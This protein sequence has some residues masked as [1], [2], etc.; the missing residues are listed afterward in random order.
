MTAW[1]PSV[2]LATTEN[3]PDDGGAPAKPL[4]PATLD[5]VTVLV[6]NH[7]LVKDQTD[8]S[9]NGTWVATT[10]PGTAMTRR[11]DTFEPESTVRVSEGD[12]NAHTSWTLRAQGAISVGVDPLLFL[13]QDTTRYAFPS[14]AAHKK[15]TAALAATTDSAA[16]A[17]LAG[18]TDPGDQGGGELVFVG[19]PTSAQIDAGTPPSAVV[20]TISAASSSS[21]GV[22]TITTST[23]HGL[24]TGA[25]TNQ[26]SVYIKDVT[27]VPDGPYLV[28]PQSATTFTLDRRFLSAS[29][30]AVPRAHYVAITTVDPHGR[31]AG[32]RLAVSGVV[33]SGGAASVNQAVF[34]GGVI[35]AHT[36]TMPI[37][38]TGGT[39]TP[40]ATAVIGD[41]AILVPATDAAGTTGGLWRR[42]QTEAQVFNVRWFGAV[43]DADSLGGGNDD[44]AAIRATIVAAKKFAAG[45]SSRGSNIAAA[46]VLFPHG[47]YRVAAASCP[48][49]V[50]GSVVLQGAQGIGAGASSVLCFDENIAYISKIFDPAHPEPV[51]TYCPLLWFAK[52]STDFTD[53]NGDN[54]I[55]RNLR[56]IQV[57]TED[58]NYLK[59]SIGVLVT[60]T[61]VSL[62]DFSL[63]SIQGDGV[64][65]SDAAGGN[66]DSWHI[67]GKCFINACER[68]GI[69]VHG[70]DANA[71][72]L[73][74]QLQIVSCKAF[75]VR[76]S[77]F[78]GNGWLGAMDLESNGAKLLPTP[79]WLFEGS[80]APSANQW[81]TGAVVTLG[82]RMVPSVAYGSMGYQF[83]CTT[84]GTTDAVNEPDWRT[85]LATPGDPIGRT[86]TEATGVEW[87]CWMEEGG[88]LFSTGGVSARTWGHVYAESDQNFSRLES[89]D[90]LIGSAGN[91][92]FTMS[93]NPLFALFGGTVIPFKI[94]SR[95]SEPYD[96][97]DV[98]RPVQ[99]FLGQY[100]DV[101]D[102][103]E[104]W[105]CGFG[106]TA[107]YPSSDVPGDYVAGY[108]LIDEFW[109]QTMLRWTRRAYEAQVA[110]PSYYGFT[111][112]SEADGK[113]G[114]QMGAVCFPSL[115]LGGVIGSERRLMALP[116]KATAPYPPDADAITTNSA[117]GA[118]NVNDL[119]VNSAASGRPTVPVL[120]RAKQTGAIKSHNTRVDSFTYPAGTVIQPN[121]APDPDVVY[122]SLNFGTT[123][124][125]APAFP[126][127]P[128]TVN[129]G[130][131]VWEYRGLFDDTSF[132]EPVVASLPT[133]LTV[134]VAAGGTITLSADE[135]AHDRIKLIGNLA[136]AVTL[137]VEPGAA[138]GWVKSFLNATD[139]AFTISVQAT[140]GGGALAATIPPQGGTPKA[141][142]LFA[143]DT[144]VYE[145]A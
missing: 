11:T 4:T 46:I 89:N 64:V 74:G 116:A 27:N 103:G 45:G 104:R 144:N 119:V 34:L 54:A 125:V 120:W 94:Q 60:A 13:R 111:Q 93:S 78:L 71:G 49:V 96:N 133:M 57:A 92:G 79:A 41:D 137:V 129:D 84:A 16:T 126:D 44:G 38:T 1:L 123:A 102:G 72:G 19:V 35:D 143:D 6:G 33:A 39:Y 138:V 56:I 73:T 134:D 23:S 42:V 8:P 82:Q 128:G 48:L 17:V 21:A 55:L 118:V 50:D 22:V 121:T 135:A 112:W 24:W 141:K 52:S 62:E 127:A 91:H 5:G 88:P 108:A 90:I 77:S 109:D 43:G 145:Y 58:R 63:D 131:I 67:G 115:W 25:A 80:A 87:T 32:E 10:P 9:L 124:A 142:L 47:I 61:G 51:S 30:G 76:E 122:V 68:Y 107:G 12:R 140:T 18:Y 31:T 29:L 3:L 130:T 106:K 40:G 69:F 132:W 15:F 117:T 37:L 97:R 65:I 26:A 139:D 100:G 95:R 7:V 2:R 81:T 83:R 70:G 20:R 28:Y 101:G 105:C 98:A 53:T 86:V 59:P 75:G 14:L 66:G 136:A 110:N 99:L 85:V 114:P 113:G 36:V